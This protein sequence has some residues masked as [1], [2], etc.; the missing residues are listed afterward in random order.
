MKKIF[1][2]RTCMMNGTVTLKTTVNAAVTRELAEKGRAACIEASK[3]PEHGFP[4]ICTDIEEIP[5]YET[6]D[7]VPI[8][9]EKKENNK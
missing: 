1:V 4:V 6:E 9:N 5:L 3:K 7:E 8:L 2:F